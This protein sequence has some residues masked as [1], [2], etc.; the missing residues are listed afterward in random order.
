MVAIFAAGGS[1]VSF[2]PL[3]GSENRT[4]LMSRRGRFFFGAP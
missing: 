4:R 3:D 2:D 1:E